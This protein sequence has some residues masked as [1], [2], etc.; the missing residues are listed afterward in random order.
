MFRRRQRSSSHELGAGYSHYH[1]RM[2]LIA[3]IHFGGLAWKPSRLSKSKLIKVQHFAL[4]KPKAFTSTHKEPSGHRRT[5]LSWDA[6]WRK[7]AGGSVSKAPRATWRTWRRLME[8]VRLPSSGQS[9]SI[10]CSRWR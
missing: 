3:G 6:R 8:A 9:A 4:G 7:P 2:N 10:I 1:G 5:D